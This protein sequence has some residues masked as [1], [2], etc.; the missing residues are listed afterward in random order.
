MTSLACHKKTKNFRLQAKRL[1]LTVA[2]LYERRF[3]LKSNEI[4]AVIDRRY[5]R[6]DRSSNESFFLQLLQMRNHRPLREAVHGRRD[7]RI[8]FLHDGLR[9]TM[10]PIPRR[11]YFLL[12]V[13]PMI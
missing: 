3:F 10:A 1:P 13:Q 12:P 4:P 7:I 8:N 6:R 11:Q 5:S 2:A 9:F